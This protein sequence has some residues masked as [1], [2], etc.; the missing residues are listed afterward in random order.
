MFVLYSRYYDEELSFHCNF[1]RAFI[2]KGCW[3]LSKAFFCIYWEDHALFVL[4]SVYMLYY[5]YRFMLNHTCISGMKLTWSWC[6]IFLMCCWILFASI[7]LNFFA[8]VFVKN[9]FVA[10][11]LGFGMSVILAS[12][13]E[14]GSVPSLSMSW[15]ILKYCY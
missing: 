10:L 13:I 9:I 4:N 1:F 11:L 7:L 15:K 5:I 6:M 8:S 3:I 14:F 2:M 12:Q